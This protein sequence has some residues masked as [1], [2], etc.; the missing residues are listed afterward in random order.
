MMPFVSLL[1]GGTGAL[2]CLTDPI[3]REILSFLDAW[4][5]LSAST[6]CRGLS[7]AAAAASSRLWSDLLVCDFQQQQQQQQQQQHQQQHQH[8][9]QPQHQPQQ[10]YMRLF[11]AH[12]QHIVRCRR[13]AARLA[14]LEENSAAHFGLRT[15]LIP[16]TSCAATCGPLLLLLLF[17]AMLSN[18]L[19]GGG[20]GDWPYSAIFFPIWILAGLLLVVFIC[21]CW[22]SR[23][24]DASAEGIGWGR[25]GWRDQW[26]YV[27]NTVPGF[28][29][30]KVLLREPRAYLH[31]GAMGVLAVFVPLC[32]CVKLDLQWQ[33]PWSIVLMPAFLLLG[34]WL[35]APLCRWSFRHHMGE[36][37]V[38]TCVLWLPFVVVM[39]LAAAKLDGAEIATHWVFMPFWVFDGLLLCLGTVATTVGAVREHRHQEGSFARTAGPFCAS[40]CLVCCFLLP[41]VLFCVFLSVEDVHDHVMSPGSIFSPLLVWLSLMFA[42]SMC[43]ARALSRS[44]MDVQRREVDFQP[45]PRLVV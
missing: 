28:V 25:R 16:L 17:V 7:C 1:A 34:L 6:T 14:V 21:T 42:F 29:V 4:S 44:N 8:Q 33:L 31:C 2:D 20:L 22:A 26:L 32:I 40:Y 27:R 37:I 23:T 39:A 38:L 10:R 24:A 5:L 19:G 35:L 3:L 30:E 9:L 13:D 36:F 43:L 15:R 41:L 12:R 45:S 18:K 11:A